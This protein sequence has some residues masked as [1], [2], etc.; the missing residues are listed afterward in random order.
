MCIHFVRYCH[1][2]HR[3]SSSFIVVHVILV[4]PRRLTSFLT[5]HRRSRHSRHASSFNVILV[6]RRH[7][8]SFL[9]IHRDS[10]SFNVFTHLYGIALHIIYVIRHLL[11][12]LHIIERRS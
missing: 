12:A 4:I 2:I 11:S 10:P 8:T 3:Y 7:L 6:M 5:I 9:I 1:I